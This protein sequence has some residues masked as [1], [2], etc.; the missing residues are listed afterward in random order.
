ML[1]LRLRRGKPRR[2]HCIS[3]Q[4]ILSVS[5]KIPNTPFRIVC[6][7]VGHLWQIQS[8]VKRPCIQGVDRQQSFDSQSQS[9]I[10]VI[11]KDLKDDMLTVQ[12]HIIKEKQY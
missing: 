4:V 1:Y 5:E 10:A 9:W 7:E 12:E 3:Q 8:L 2:A 6:L 11:A